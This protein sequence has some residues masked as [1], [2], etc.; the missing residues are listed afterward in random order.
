VYV[1]GYLR[2]MEIFDVRSVLAQITNN[3]YLVKFKRYK[4]VLAELA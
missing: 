3:F 4:Q 2:R 1:T